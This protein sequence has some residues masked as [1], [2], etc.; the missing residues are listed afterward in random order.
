M[1]SYVSAK[2]L[3]YEEEQRKT[4]QQMVETGQPH[5]LEE[6]KRKGTQ[7]SYMLHKSH[8]MTKIKRTAWT[9]KIA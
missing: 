5:V 2:K 1:V 9:G 7:T 8:F 3:E 6:E 4:L